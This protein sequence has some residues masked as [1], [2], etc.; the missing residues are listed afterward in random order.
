MVCVPAEVSWKTTPPIDECREKPQPDGR[1]EDPVVVGGGRPG[2]P[3]GGDRD[4]DEGR[5]ADQQVDRTA[6][7]VAE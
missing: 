5:Q 4:R 3:D 2:E 1:R 6:R 7:P